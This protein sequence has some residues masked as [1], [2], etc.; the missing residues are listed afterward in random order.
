MKTK[1]TEHKETLENGQVHKLYVF[2]YYVSEDTLNNRD[3]TVYYINNYNN[4][5]STR[6]K[7]SNKYTNLQVRNL[8]EHYMHS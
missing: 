1:G 7:K 8:K 4:I 2:F 6:F 5:L 3:T